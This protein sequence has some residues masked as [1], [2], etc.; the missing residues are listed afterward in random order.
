MAKSSV[1]DQRTWHRYQKLAPTAKLRDDV[2]GHLP[3]A[4]QWQSCISRGVHANVCR[5]CSRTCIKKA[6]LHLEGVVCSARQQHCAGAREAQTANITVLLVTPLKVGL[7]ARHIRPVLLGHHLCLRNCHL[8]D[9]S[10]APHLA[11]ANKDPRALAM[12]GAMAV[13][14][15]DILAQCHTKQTNAQLILA[16]PTFN[17]VPK[18]PEEQ[19]GY[20]PK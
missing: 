3:D 6:D 10:R 17:A 13:I 20:D 12:H 14:Q 19:I 2:A 16:T 5:D 18:L 11:C 4:I 8:P 7:G 15:G 1:D 9:C